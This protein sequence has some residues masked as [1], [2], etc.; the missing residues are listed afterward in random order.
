MFAIL[1]ANGIILHALVM[2]NVKLIGVEIESKFSEVSKTEGRY[3]Q[4][5]RENG[6]S[7]LEHLLEIIQEISNERHD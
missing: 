1:L 6:I 5:L 7:D 2:S 4:D 3:A